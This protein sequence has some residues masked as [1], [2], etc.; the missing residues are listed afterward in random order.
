MNVALIGSV[1]SSYTALEALVASG[2]EITAVLGLDESQAESTCDYRALGEVAARAGL[3]FQPFIKVADPLVEQFLGAHPPDLLWVIGLSQ[4]VPDR[5]I[6]M[7]R[8]GGI[9]FHPT[10][11]PEGRGRAPVA[12]TILLGR[13]AAVNLFFLTEEPDAGDLIVQR[14]VPVLPDDYSEDLIRRTNDALREVILELAPRI[15][16]GNLPRSPQ[17]HRQATYYKKR[18]AADGRIDFAEPTAQVY[19][20]VRAAGRPYHGAFSYASRDKVIVWR[21]VPAR[22]EEIPPSQMAAIPGTI[23][24]VDPGRGALVRTG[25]GGLWLTET[26]VRAHPTGASSNALAVGMKLGNENARPIQLRRSRSGAP[27]GPVT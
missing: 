10:M 19:R 15:K 11:L 22:L 13:R 21:A 3:P 20:L 26:E 25:D 8:Q 6:E 27:E 16:E 23:V 18:T 12:W 5:L 9:G 24:R 2:V 14:E 7:A 1:S 17:D 4:L